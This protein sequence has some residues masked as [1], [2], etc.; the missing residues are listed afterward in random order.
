MEVTGGTLSG[1]V[2]GGETTSGNATGNS[3]DFSNVTATYVQGGYSGSGSATGN[4]LA[5]HS[6]TVQNNAFG[7]YVDSGNGAASG[8]SV[9]FNGGSVTNNI[10]GGMSAGGLVQ[11]NSVNMTNGSAKWLLG[12]YS[13]SGDASGNSVKVSG[14]TLTGV[15]GGESNSGSATG[16]IVSISGGT[17]QSNVNGGYVQNGS[18]AATGNIVNISGKADLSGVAVAGGYSPNGDAFTGNTL[19][20]NSD[21]AV[22]VARNFASVNFNYSGNANIGELESAP[23]G[24]ALS[25]V[26]VN[27]N[28]NTVSFDG[29]I[30]YSGS[31][32]KTGAGTLIL[33]GT[34]T[35]SGGT[36]ISAG[37]LRL[38]NASAAGSGNISGGLTRNAAFGTLDLAFDGAYGNN[39]TGN[40]NL[41]AA[42]G[43]GKTL[44]LSGA[45]TYI[46]MTTVM[47]GTLN[48][49]TNDLA[50]S[51]GLTLYGG[52]AFDNSS[53]R[54]SLDN[55]QL[56]VNA[57]NG[58]TATYTG[59][60]YARNAVLNF[61]SSTTPERHGRRR[62]H[63]QRL[64]RGAG[65]RHLPGRR[66]QPDPARSRRW[67]DAYG[68]QSAARRRH[69][70]DWLHCG[71]RH[72]RQHR[73]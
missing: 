28:D 9:T 52:A 21:A 43:S 12:G 62:C 53:G 54:H 5:I 57:A 70:T 44:T 22:K 60:L 64:Q 50:A 31:M 66:F 73:H 39:I 63:G 14:G 26:T 11:N 6:G 1:G 51:S 41:S 27:T 4:S 19:N 20:K 37:I 3:V 24:S 65:G 30:S 45:S 59:D 36:T 49:G 33:S 61:I 18:G 29:I 10:Y 17:V 7:G 67:Q 2:N 46:G 25:G 47:S 58:Q 40:L 42:P 35:Y 68:K 13:N 72:Y 32:T 8:N 69:H 16:N 15:S 55:K 71:A 48:P 56:N 23:T 34:N 38:T